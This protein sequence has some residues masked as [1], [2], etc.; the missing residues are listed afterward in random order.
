MQVIS[1][2]LNLVAKSAAGV[3]KPAKITY[4]HEIAFITRNESKMSGAAAGIHRKHHLKSSCAERSRRLN[5]L[6][7]T[8]RI[9]LTTTGSSIDEHAQEQKRQLLLFLDANHRIVSGMNAEI[10]I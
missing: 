10:G 6:F 2:E 4:V 3:H 7:G 9:A 1:G 5:Q 8:A